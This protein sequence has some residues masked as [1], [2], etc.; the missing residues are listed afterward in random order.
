MKTVTA[1]P[2]SA[3]FRLFNTNSIAALESSA[4][5]QVT[6]L[7]YGERM[8]QGSWPDFLTH[9]PELPGAQETHN[10]YGVVLRNQGQEKKVSRVRS[11]HWL[12]VLGKGLCWG[13]KWMQL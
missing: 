3:H 11:D 6:A 13:C 5:V 4:E 9:T 10:T 7:L 12:S 8:Q 1:A 2:T